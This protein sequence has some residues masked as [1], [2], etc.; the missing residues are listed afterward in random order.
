MTPKIVAHLIGD[1]MIPQGIF[2]F[3]TFPLVLAHQFQRNPEASNHIS[4]NPPSFYKILH[5]LP[6]QLRFYGQSD[7]IVILGATNRS[8]AIDPALLRPGR[9]EPEI[10]RW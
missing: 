8:E 6:I 7:G 1:L 4:S 2:G 5:G 9:R 10:G 3:S